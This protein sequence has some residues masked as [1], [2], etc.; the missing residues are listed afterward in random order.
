MV[1]MH[2]IAFPRAAPP[3]WAALSHFFPMFVYFYLFDVP[4]FLENHSIASIF[5][6]CSWFYSESYLPKQTF[7]QHLPLCQEQFWGISWSIL[8]YSFFFLR[9]LPHTFLWNFVH[10]FFILLSRS[11]ELRKISQHV[12]LWWGHYALSLCLFW[13]FLSTS[14]KIWNILLICCVNILI[15]FF[16]ET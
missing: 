6:R 14:W 7:S 13:V 11:K 10:M 2:K 5:Y 3:W 12:S 8:V 1:Q 9:A 15:N 16:F 4:L